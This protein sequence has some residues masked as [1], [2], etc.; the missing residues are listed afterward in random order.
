LVLL[1]SLE[2]LGQTKHK[3]KKEKK[4]EE[5]NM[6]IY[7]HTHTFKMTVSVCL[8]TRQNDNPVVH[9]MCKHVFM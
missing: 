9:Q 7:T 2:T 6:S 8:V 1:T 4:K 5:D 3:K